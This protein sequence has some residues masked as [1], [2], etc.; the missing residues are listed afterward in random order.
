MLRVTVSN[1]AVAE[2]LPLKPIK[3]HTDMLCPGTLVKLLS[4]TTKR[5]KLLTLV[6]MK[7]IQALVDA[8]AA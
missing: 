1:A 7:D 4:V 5:F 6:G 8:P 2:G 3:Q